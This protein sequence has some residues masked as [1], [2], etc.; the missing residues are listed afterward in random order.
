MILDERWE[1]GR[2]RKLHTPLSTLQTE[3]ESAVGIGQLVGL[4]ISFTLGIH[5]DGSDLLLGNRPVSSAGSGSCDGIHNIHTG[6]H[7]AESS[8]LLVQ[9]LGIL[10]HD[11]EL[12]AGG[13]GA[14]G[15]GHGQDTTLVTQVILN[16][17]KEELAFDAVAGA[18]HA[19]ALRA[20]TLNHETGDNAME[21]QTVIVVVIGQIDEVIH[22]LGS[23]FGI[24]LA[25][26]DATV[27]HGDLKSRICHIIS[28]SPS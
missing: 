21:D 28:F 6:G 16:T 24:Q 26:D 23:L 13:V 27:F 19:G 7:L 14:L 11:E 10:V 4:G 15:T 2:W 20:A 5:S 22:A 3:L 18:A 9:M 17:V 1:R 8:V 25:F 12:G